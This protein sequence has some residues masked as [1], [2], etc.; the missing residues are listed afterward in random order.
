M[1]RVQAAVRAAS[2]SSSGVVMERTMSCGVNFSVTVMKWTATRAGSG[3]SAGLSCQSARQVRAKG[4]W[5]W[6]SVW[7]WVWAWVWIC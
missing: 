1:C 3:V 4:A 5:V 6:V 2:L 7:M